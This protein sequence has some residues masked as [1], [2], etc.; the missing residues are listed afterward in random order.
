MSDPAPYRDLTEQDEV[1]ALMAPDGGAV[2][3]DFWSQ[4]CGPCMAMAD[5]F[6]AV[7]AQFDPGEV[8]FVKVDVGRHGNLAAPFK[9]MSVP[10]ILFVLNGQI[11]DSFVGRPTAR[12][13][14][15]RA[16]WLVKRSQKRGIL[17]RLFGGA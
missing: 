16:E 4:T 10:T 13:L 3:L 11:L 5:D 12:K 1:E 6:A 8:Q 17:S 14:G 9:V 7:A 2:V 15:E